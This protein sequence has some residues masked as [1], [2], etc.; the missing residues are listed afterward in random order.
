[1]KSWFFTVFRTLV[2]LVGLFISDGV[3]AQ[4]GGCG[5]L[6]VNMETPDPCLWR[7]HLDNHNDACYDDLRIILDSGE[8]TGWSTTAGWTAVQISPTEIELNHTSGIIPFGQSLP[9]GFTI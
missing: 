1:M 4:G 3:S 7:L 2:M 6:L 9:I 8:F 5:E